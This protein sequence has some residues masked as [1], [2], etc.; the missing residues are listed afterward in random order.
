[1]KHEGVTVLSC[2]IE[3][4]EFKSDYYKKNIKAVNEFY[5]DSA[6]ASQSSSRTKFYQMAVVQHMNMRPCRH[7]MKKS[8]Y[9]SSKGVVVYLQ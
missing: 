1:M 6:L 3:Y 4:L 8:F 7:L 5:K 2:Q 9:C